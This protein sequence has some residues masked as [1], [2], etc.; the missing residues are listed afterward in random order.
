MQA[1]GVGGGNAEMF[2]YQARAFLDRITGGSRPAATFS[3]RRT[4]GDSVRVS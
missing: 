3:R 2:T 4:G 1:P